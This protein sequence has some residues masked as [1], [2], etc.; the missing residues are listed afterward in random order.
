MLMPQVSSCA[1]EECAYNT[2]S[3]CHAM[4]ITI[5]D[6]VGVHAMCD[7]FFRT[8]LFGGAKDQVGG[9]GACKVSACR[10]NEDLECMA[11][12]VQVGYDRDH[13]DCLTFAKR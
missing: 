10:F 2:H 11:E 8:S 9:V 1:V 12:S 7:T 13:A 5:G 6:G 4:A 3:I